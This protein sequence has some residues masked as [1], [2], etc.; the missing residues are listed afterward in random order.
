MITFNGLRR[1]G[2][3]AVFVVLAPTL[4]FSAN[5]QD[6]A[7]KLTVLQALSIALTNSSIL[8]IATSRLEQPS[9]RYAQSRAPLLPQLDV[10]VRQSYQTI[11]LIGLGISNPTVTESK[12]DDRA[13]CHLERCS[14]ECVVAEPDRTGR[15]C[16]RAVLDPCRALPKAIGTAIATNRKFRARG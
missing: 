9:G 4:A 5:Q 12:S 3:T 6:L 16:N 8:R 11:S 10:N 1:A 13:R 14:V 2:F 15:V 7:K